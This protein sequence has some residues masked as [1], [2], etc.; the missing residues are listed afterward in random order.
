[1]WREIP[2][3]AIYTEPQKKNK[4][5]SA[6]HLTSPMFSNNE[7]AKLRRA[8][9]EPI[10][11]GGDTPEHNARTDTAVSALG[12]PTNARRPQPWERKIA[13]EREREMSAVPGN[14]NKLKM[15]S[16]GRYY[17]AY[18]IYDVANSCLAT[19]HAKT[20]TASGRATGVVAPT[21]VRPLSPVHVQN[22]REFLIFRGACQLNS[23]DIAI[24]FDV[25]LV[26]DNWY[27]VESKILEYRAKGQESNYK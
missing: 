7:M 13:R 20:P 6:A 10:Y 12:T 14:R 21:I 27:V 3:N 11:L 23:H 5:T 25:F 16:A 22:P 8:T 4:S 1:M 9:W 18:L 24:G 26:L 2:N 15:G 19:V 17:G